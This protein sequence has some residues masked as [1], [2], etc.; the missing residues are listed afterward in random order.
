MKVRRGMIGNR[1]IDGRLFIGE[2]V[3][4][5]VGLHVLDTAID[6]FHIRPKSLNRG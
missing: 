1:L 6:S 4:Y 5:G 2:G 3:T